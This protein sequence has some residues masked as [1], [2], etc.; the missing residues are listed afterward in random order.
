MCPQT[1]LLI[2][3]EKLFEAENNEKSPLYKSVSQIQHKLDNEIKQFRSGIADIMSEMQP[4][5]N[6]IIE[7]ISK[8]I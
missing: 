3:M 1:N 7:K 2:D 8:I 4:V 5:K 6:Q